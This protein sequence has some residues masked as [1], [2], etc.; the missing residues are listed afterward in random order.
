MKGWIDALLFWFSVLFFSQEKLDFAMQE[1][2]FELLSI[3]QR[4]NKAQHPEVCFACT[5]GV[6]VDRSVVCVGCVSRD[7]GEL[8]RYLT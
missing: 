3:N 1:I 6:L 4:P 5:G 2:I 7:P 8:L